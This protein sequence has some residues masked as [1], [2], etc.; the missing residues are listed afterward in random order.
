MKNLIIVLCTV[1]IVYV[2]I[3]IPVYAE[4]SNSDKKTDS[5]NLASKAK[6]AILL[7]QD[8]GTILYDKNANEKLPPAS[9]TKI[10]TLLLIMEA[11][12][13]EKIDLDE[14]VRISEYAAS[15]G[16]SQI[17][18]EAGEEMTVN[19][20]L[21]GVAIASGN[22]ASVALAE[23]IAGSEEE[24]VKKMNEKVK[25]LGLENTK[26]QNPTGLPAED[27][28]STA[29]DMAVIAQHLLNHE[30]ITDYTSVYED[31]LRKGQEDEFWLVN[32]NKL[33]K[34]YPGVDGLKTG[35]TSEAKYCLTAT[36]K[37]NDMRVVTVVMGA[38]SPKVRNSIVSNM[39]D[40]SFQHFETT[41]LYKKGEQVAK[42]DLLKAKKSDIKVVSSQP[43]STVHKKGE[44]V[45]NFTTSVKLDQAIAP[46]LKKGEQVG[47]L[48]VKNG[49]KVLSET[50][51]ILEENADTANVFTLF[52]RTLQKI[53]KY[54]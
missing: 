4:E 39:L 42:L 47:T 13:N 53:A 43:I 9:M 16:G 31:Y 24:F 14:K 32:T 8:T 22:D 29:Y 54:N 51:L 49:D 7:E 5:L 41:N 37:K 10:M 2:G 26:F 28:Y 1:F 20:L 21:K 48:V 30:E 38:E 36:A 40:Y 3:S 52:N 12:D 18:L 15:M 44:K 17:F 34:F 25:E 19:D 23:R 45:E 50:P 6:S 11:L 46:P 35:Y 27:H 33:V